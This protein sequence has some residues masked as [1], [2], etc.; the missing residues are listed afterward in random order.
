MKVENWQPPVKQLKT[1][2]KSMKTKNCRRLSPA[3]PAYFLVSKCWI[4]YFS[5]KNDQL[6]FSQRKR[7]QKTKTVHMKN[8]CK[9]KVFVQDRQVFFQTQQVPSLPVLI[10]SCKEVES[11]FKGC[12][13]Y[14][15]IRA[16]FLTRRSSCAL[17]TL[18]SW[19]KEKRNHCTNNHPT[20]YVSALLE[21]APSACQL[22]L[23]KV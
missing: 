9:Q 3:T 17:W 23:L 2:H 21:F 4:S 15:G 6:Q 7:K 10:L 8:C 1:L 20:G 16:V 13:V 22:S 14:A 18:F 11:Q 5:S 19:Q 12:A